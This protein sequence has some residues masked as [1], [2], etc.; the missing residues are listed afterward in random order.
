MLESLSLA[1]MRLKAPQ[2]RLSAQRVTTMVMRVVLSVTSAVQ[3]TSAMG[4]DTPKTPGLSAKL[5]IIAHPT[6]PSLQR[7]L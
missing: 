5:A 3:V 2:S 1:T 4:W 6:I 7:Q